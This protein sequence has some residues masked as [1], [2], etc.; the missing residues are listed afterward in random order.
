MIGIYKIT[1]PSGK[2]YI[3]QAVDIKRRWREHRSKASWYLCK[4]Y[5][6]FKSYGVQKHTFEIIE[7]RLWEELNHKERYYQEKYNTVERGLNHYYQQTDDLP[8]KHSK[9]T[10]RKMSEVRK[11]QTKSEEHRRK[12]SESMKGKKK[13]VEHKRKMA[14]AKRGKIGPWKGKKDLKKLNVR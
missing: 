12:I 14:E 10:V 13:S 8:L 5:N 2:V 9:E 7:E 3:G 4:L 11:G 6:S 1:N